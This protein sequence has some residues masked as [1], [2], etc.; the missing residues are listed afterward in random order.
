MTIL[1][2]SEKKLL[3]EVFKLISEKIVLKILRMYITTVYVCKCCHK[4]ILS[5]DFFG[6]VL[7]KTHK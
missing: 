2:L 6:S 3:L 7:L 5:S 1:F 4:T